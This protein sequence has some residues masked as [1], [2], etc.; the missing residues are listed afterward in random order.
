MPRKTWHIAEENKTLQKKI[1]E[2]CGITSVT[3]QILINR[4]IT[5]P[6]QANDFLKSD[7]SSL[8]DPF[9]MKDMKKAVERI[10]KA[11]SRGEKVMIYGDYDADGI[12]AAAL[13]KRV[14]L[15]I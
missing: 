6:A 3:A 13:L 5:E 14:L 4:G 15:D 9:I 11:I 12:S 7:I 8:H 2:E 10:K 1:A